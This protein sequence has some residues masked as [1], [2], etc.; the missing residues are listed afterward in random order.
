MNRAA[1][2]TLLLGRRFG[3]SIVAALLHVLPPNLSS[4]KLALYV[5]VFLLPGGSFVV[6][7]AAWFENRRP[8]KPA[9]PAPTK[10][11]L[12]CRPKHCDA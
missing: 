10:T 2:T 4:W 1:Q 6:L 3:H 5:I 9:K 11:P 12:L 8:R 7:G